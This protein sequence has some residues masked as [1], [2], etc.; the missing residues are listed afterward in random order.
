VCL[1]GNMF[2]DYMVFTIMSGFISL[3][4]LVALLGLAILV[5]T[6]QAFIFS[7]LTTVYIG[8]S[9]PHHDHDHDHH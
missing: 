8:L 6:I 4:L 2:G 3:L 5:S 7:L 9:V 1:T